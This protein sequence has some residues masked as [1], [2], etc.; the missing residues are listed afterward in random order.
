[1]TTT[2]G[3]S[4]VLQG[5]PWKTY[6]CLVETI[7]NP[8]V[9]LTYDNGSL[10]IMSPTPAHE[11]RNRRLSS[12][13]EALADV[14]EIEIENFGAATFRHTGMTRGTEPDT[15]F[16]VQR[17]QAVM[18]R[19]DINLNTGDPAPDLVIEVDVTSDSINKLPIYERFGVPEVWRM[20]EDHVSLLLL[21][22][23]GYVEGRQSAA[24][25][26]LSAAQLN[27]F[28]KRG[29]TQSRL[30]WLREVRAWAETQSQ[31]SETSDDNL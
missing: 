17:V 18:G 4:V 20:D 10:E 30:L 26:L 24:L 14:W 6:E 31:L 9:R 15:C 19:E 8:G 23:N 2:S 5:V 29:A 25:P 16:Y 12:F 11:K 27:A 7:N 28:M 22:E 21:S 13:V 1:M 3:A